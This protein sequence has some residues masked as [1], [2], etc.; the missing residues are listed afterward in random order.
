[1]SHDE[2]VTI[3]GQ[4]WEVVVTHN[5]LESPTDRLPAIQRDWS[6]LKA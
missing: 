4:M 3:F 2:L 1:M 5:D 6:E